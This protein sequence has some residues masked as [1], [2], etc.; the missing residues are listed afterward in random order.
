MTTMLIAVPSLSF[1][2]RLGPRI[3]MSLPSFR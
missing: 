1:G 3:R 2:R